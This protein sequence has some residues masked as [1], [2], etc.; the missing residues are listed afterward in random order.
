MSFNGVYNITLGSDPPSSN[1]ASVA[2]TGSNSSIGT[3][4]YNASDAAQQWSVVPVGG[5]VVDGYIIQSADMKQYINLSA[6]STLIPTFN[7][8]YLW[9]IKCSSGLISTTSSTNWLPN[10]TDPLLSLTNSL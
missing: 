1:S 6:N 3:I 2:I 5:S 4:P 8:S 10:A 7:S 9:I